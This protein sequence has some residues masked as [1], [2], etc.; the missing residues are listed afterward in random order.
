MSR[1][2]EKLLERARL[3]EEVIGAVCLDTQVALDEIG[4]LLD[5]VDTNDFEENE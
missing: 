3:E 4:Y 5:G 2:I 1:N